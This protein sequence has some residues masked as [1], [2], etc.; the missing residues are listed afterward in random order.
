MVCAYVGIKIDH[1]GFVSVIS[2]FVAFA[3][4]AAAV[5]HAAAATIEYE[6]DLWICSSPNA[7]DDFTG[8]CICM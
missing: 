7:H 5:S 2:Y 6:Q 8:M 4:S 1:M 3:S